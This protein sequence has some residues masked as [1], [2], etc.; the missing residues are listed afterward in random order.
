MFIDILNKNLFVKKYFLFI[1][2]FFVVGSFAQTQ[3]CTLK[4]RYLHVSQCQAGTN[5][6]YLT[7]ISIDNNP[8]HVNVCDSARIE[9]ESQTLDLSHRYLRNNFCEATY[10]GADVITRFIVGDTPNLPSACAGDIFRRSVPA[11][12]EM[13][14]TWDLQN[15]STY[16]HSSNC[17]QTEWANGF[18]LDSIIRMG[19]DGS[20][21]SQNT[22]LGDTARVILE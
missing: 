20:S 5:P 4:N 6:N 12:G 10:H 2:C 21:I 14:P 1:L 15:G 19:V 8:N 18:F 16:L 17:I 22:C 3:V 7:R 13:P 9:V 11:S